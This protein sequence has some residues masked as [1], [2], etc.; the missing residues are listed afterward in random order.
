MY[1]T[2]GALE[3]MLRAQ[4][5]QT[6][7]GPSETPGE[8][9][10]EGMIVDVKRN[11]K[12]NS[13]RDRS[14]IIRCRVNG[15]FD[16][17]IIQTGELL[18]NINSSLLRV[19][20]P[21][22]EMLNPAEDSPQHG[23]NVQKK[24]IYRE[25]Q[26]VQ[27]QALVGAKWF[28]GYVEKAYARGIYKIEY[29][30]GSY[31]DNVPS[32]RLRPCSDREHNQSASFKFVGPSLLRVGD[33][34]RGA[35]SDME[36]TRLVQPEQ[37]YIGQQVLMRFVYGL[38]WRLG[39]IMKVRENGQAYDV[40]L[41]GRQEVEKGV[42]ASFV[43]HVS[44]MLYGCGNDP[45]LGRQI[46][47]STATSMGTPFK[48]SQ[49][50]A[51][52]GTGRMKSSN[53]ATDSPVHGGKD[54][55]NGGQSNLQ[56]IK[57]GRLGY[58]LRET[59]TV[60]NDVNALIPPAQMVNG[61]DARQGVSALA[62]RDRY[63]QEMHRGAALLNAS[64]AERKLTRLVRQEKIRIR[65]VLRIQALVRG[66][67]ARAYA[68]AK[69]QVM[70]R[71][72]ALSN[73]EAQLIREKKELLDRYAEALSLA[74]SRD[75]IKRK[76]AMQGDLEEA[77]HSM[78]PQPATSPHSNLRI[79]ETL[80][81]FRNAVMDEGKQHAVAMDKMRAELV[82]IHQH[83]MAVQ[84][85]EL[86]NLFEREIRGLGQVVLDAV[87]QIPSPTSVSVDRNARCESP[88]NVSFLGNDSAAVAPIDVVAEAPMVAVSET[89]ELDADR[90]CTEDGGNSH[91]E[92]IY[93]C[94]FAPRMMSLCD[95][96]DMFLSL[97]G[98]SSMEHI[99]IVSVVA[100][101]TVSYSVQTA[102]LDNEIMP[103]IHVLQDAEEFKP[104]H[105]MMFVN[106]ATPGPF[107]LLKVRLDSDEGRS[108]KL[109]FPSE[110]IGDICACR[111]AVN[112]TMDERTKF[113]F[114]AASL[115]VDALAGL[116]G[117]LWNA[118]LSWTSQQVLV[119]LAL[120]KNLQNMVK[121]YL[122]H[123]SISSTDLEVSA[124]SVSW[125]S[126]RYSLYE[127][128]LS[129]RKEHNDAKDHYNATVL[130][131]VNE[132]RHVL[133]KWG[134]FHKREGSEVEDDDSTFAVVGFSDALLD[135]AGTIMSPFHSFIF[136][137]G[138]VDDDKPF[139]MSHFNDALRSNYGSE[140]C[141]S[142]LLK[143]I[144]TDFANSLHIASVFESFL[145][146][147]MQL[148]HQTLVQAFAHPEIFNWK[149]WYSSNAQWVATV[150]V[151]VI[152]GI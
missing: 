41:S 111:K 119:S 77:V 146:T 33:G 152:A 124:T 47:S 130:N 118:H 24:D 137:A 140:F 36:E 97:W 90:G 21:P 114:Y 52:P 48:S 70:D 50:V 29:L 123:F 128:M 49:T 84:R 88:A 63:A 87:K 109:K 9:F 81:Q 15:T 68:R 80:H 148:S 57:L 93:D 76:D 22:E 4:N 143:R 95:M 100:S 37:F 51:S 39:T 46:A 74:V 60:D 56:A 30:D 89:S 5:F 18:V 108:C 102:Q 106:D 13:E 82:A 8:R 139:D 78:P 125:L 19:P 144:Y 23:S 92:V 151:S 131:I 44:S 86:E 69:L 43:R 25:N 20:P 98:N 96:K 59:R 122:G 85:K 53:R 55:K 134:Y 14:V 1:A 54:Q 27:C 72:K 104:V 64:A 91:S 112:I 71:R 34:Q 16:A 126:E 65:S 133:S 67:L 2:A 75:E 10:F 129:I 101:S 103:P 66:F 45:A 138:V 94:G 99:E 26:R 115:R 83:E 61:K 145:P 135:L 32:K 38:T 150:V 58:V 31:E 12:V 79:E 17:E 121:Q 113:E 132:L 120:H 62:L 141:V 11:M 73:G 107:Y 35:D 105:W 127:D 3:T 142:P 7:F 147:V 110:K 117:A 136:Y 6:N 40:L 42:P 149:E 28:T 116:M